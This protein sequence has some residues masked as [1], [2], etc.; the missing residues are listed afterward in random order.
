[1]PV[2][3]RHLGLAHQAAPL[4]PRQMRLVA[5]IG[6]AALDREARVG[7]ARIDAAPVIGALNRAGDEG[8]VDQR[9][10]LD[11]EAARVELAIGLRQQRL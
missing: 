4:A 7:V 8:R 11:D 1:M 10:G 6:L 3:R 9:A 5:E 2:G